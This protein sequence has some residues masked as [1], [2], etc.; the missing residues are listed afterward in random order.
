ME[1]L[2]NSPKVPPRSIPRWRLVI[3][4]SLITQEIRDWHYEGS[5][6]PADPF[7]V[8]WIEND[9]RNPM[10]LPL[11]Q[12]W[13]LVIILSISTMAVSLVSSGYVGALPQIKEAFD[14]SDIMAILGVSLYVLGFALG[15]ILW[16]PFSEVYG[17]Q[18]IFL[19]TYGAMTLFNVGA[20]F[21]PN[22]QSMLIMRFFAGTFGAAPDQHR[23]GHCRHFPRRATRH[24]HQPVRHR[25]VP[26]PRARPHR[27]RIPCQAGG[28]KWVLILMAVF[29]AVC[30]VMCAALVP[31]TFAPL[32]L[33][34]RAERL[35]KE[36]GK[37]YVCH[38][39]ISKGR[40]S[41]MDDLKVSLVRPWLLLFH[42]PIVLALT[43]YMSIVYG[44][45]YL[46]FAAYPFVYQHGRGWSQ[47]MNGLAFLGLMVGLILGV[48]Y[49]MIDNSR[50]TRLLAETGRPPPEARLLPMMVGSIVLP[51]GLFW[52][53]WTNSPSIH[54]MSSIAASTFFGFAFALVFVSAKNYLV[55][56]YT[57]FSASALA[58]TVIIRSLFAMAFPLF[59]PYMYR[60]LGIHWASSI[61]AFLSLACVPFPFVFHKF[62]PTIRKKCKYSREAQLF[63]ER[64]GK[65]EHSEEEPTSSEVD[66]TQM[67]QKGSVEAKL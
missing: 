62:G 64:N 32:L 36:T 16:A 42:E 31:E 2:E 6:T 9:P 45:L 22:I 66:T 18:L 10:S 20:I 61:P 26:R 33:R 8:D 27:G 51:V 34:K 52:F 48:V 13:I 23:R 46:L 25:P 12:R 59:T 47:G 67:P 4:Q 35:S 19:V 56:S 11:M 41:F 24:G 58:S 29:C 37:Q 39:D 49:N 38:F 28:W 54:W 63:L 57:L 30:W 43:I 14:V 50:Y 53:A 55:D 40:P 15:P 5:G 21:S 60:N 44:T 1:P 65:A 17:R 3:D 7:V